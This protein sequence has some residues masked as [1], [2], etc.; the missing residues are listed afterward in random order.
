MKLLSKRAGKLC[1]VQSDYYCFVPTSLFSINIEKDEEMSLLLDEANMC[2]GKLDGLAINLPDKDIFIAK[3]VEKEAVLSSQIEGTQ[4]SLSDVFQVDKLDDEIRKETKE[5][6]NYVNALDLGIS[7]LKSLPLCL[8][9]F[10]QL[11]KTLLLGVR[12]WK[13]NPGEVRRSQNWIGPKGYTLKEATFIPPSVDYLNV[14]ITDLEKFINT[15]NNMSLLIKIA[16][17]HYQFETI[18]PFLD[19][20]GRVGRILIPLFLINNKILSNPIMYLSLFFRKNRR[21]YYDLLMDV[22]FKGHYEQ[23]I[24]FFLKGVIETSNNAVETINQII[25]LR[26][27]ISKKLDRLKIHN[28]QLVSDAIMFL[29]QHPYINSNDLRKRFSISKPTTSSLIKTL[30]KMNIIVKTDKKQR[31]STYRFDKYV[32]ILEEGTNL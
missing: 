19:G 28:K 1:Y 21:E 13:Q 7:L 2:L 11:H 29:Y 5:I 4:V 8:R 25:K 22:R 12:G 20:N 3:Y 27:D 18:H 6:V 24:K 9:Y 23:W 14:L 30:Q 31:N 16:L 10:K 15:E 32:Q 17:I 26:S